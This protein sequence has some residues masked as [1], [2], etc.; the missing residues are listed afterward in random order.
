M[1]IAN[2]DITSICQ[3]A[4]VTYENGEITDQ[5]HTLI[6]PK[7]YFHEINVMIHGIT[8]RKVK[9]APTLSDVADMIKEKFADNLICS[10]GAFDRSSLTRIF[11][12]LPNQWLDI[13]RVVRRS[14]DKQFAKYG[15]GLSSMAEALK[16]NQE[17]HHDALDDVLVAG[18]ILLKALADSQQDLEFWLDR[19]RKP[20]DLDNYQKANSKL[21]GNP[22]GSLYG[23]TIVFTGELSIPRAKAAEMAAQAGCNVATGVSKKVTLLVIGEQDVTKLAGKELSSKEIK[24]RE[25]IEKGYPI[26]LLSE[27][28]FYHLINCEINVTPKRPKTKNHREK[29]SKDNELSEISLKLSIIINEDGEIKIESK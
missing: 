16:I 25:L 21:E 10:Y 17:N 8:E 9:N 27:N 14:W 12:E 18:Q 1:W 7:T 24:A 5:W 19:V 22:E 15:Y 6:N 13:V 2:P 23:E 3:I 26:Q 29:Q 11:P 20:I 28:D 4:I